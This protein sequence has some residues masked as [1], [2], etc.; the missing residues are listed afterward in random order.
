[1][2]NGCR[3]SSD[4][5]AATLTALGLDSV[6]T[7]QQPDFDSFLELVRKQASLTLRPVEYESEKILL[8]EREKVLT[9]YFSETAVMAL[10]MAMA[11]Q[12][13]EIA[14]VGRHGAVGALAA[15]D[16]G[17][18]PHRAVVLVGGRGFTCSAARFREAALENP[19]L[20]DATLRL[21]RQISAQYAQVAVC[22]IAHL[23]APRLARWLARV[24]DLTGQTKLGFTQEKMAEWLGV[25]RT[26]ITLAATHLNKLGAISYGRGV[27]RITDL[28]KLR[29]TACH[30]YRA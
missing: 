1:V 26:S 28:A 23:L 25:R 20:L 6:S 27:V 10:R 30:C 4:L 12:W 13:I 22:N 9:V 24:H 18:V 29:A 15:L 16:G 5:Q 21:E 3:N 2:R 14:T 17:T 8:T 19:A 7:K 11:E